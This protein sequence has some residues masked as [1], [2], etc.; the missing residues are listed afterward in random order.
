MAEGILLEAGTNEMELL[1][2]R[3]GNTPMGINVAKVREIVQCPDNIIKIPHAPF[4]VEG[5]FK[6]RDSIMS[7]VNLGQY[8]NMTI[9]YDTGD[10]PEQKNPAMIIVVEFNAIQCG[11]LV[12]AVERIHRLSWDNIHRPSDIL[13]DMNVPV[14]GTVNIDNKTVLIV[15]FETVISQILG[16]ESAPEPEDLIANPVCTAERKDI[17]ILLADD[18]I[19]IRSSLI[20]ILKDAGFEKLVVCS[21]GQQAW[22]YVNTHRNDENG[23]CDL[24]MTDIEMPR[25][26]GLHLTSRIKKDESLKHIPVVLFSSLVTDDNI[27]KGKSVGADA[28]VSKPDSKNMLNAI[29]SCLSDR[30]APV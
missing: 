28:Q 6:L 12:D 11:I 8:F 5:S 9:K 15:D 7:L 18:S 20:K 3:L 22:E 25:M 17:R 23:P 30:L 2:F 29:E 10:A 16:I 14:T 4:A 1:V 24:V 21:D 26:D 19:V 13:I 27:K